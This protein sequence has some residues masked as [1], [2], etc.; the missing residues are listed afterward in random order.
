MRYA[1]SP[2]CRISLVSL[3]QVKRRAVF[4]Q[5]HLCEVTSDKSDPT[6]ILGGLNWQVP[7]DLAY[8]VEFFLHLLWKPLKGDPEPL[9][10]SCQ[11]IPR[12]GCVVVGLDEP[13]QKL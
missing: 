7:F 9:W 2:K 6:R 12:I 5:L 1:Y 8:V 13:S 11:H 4:D 3:D 10:Y